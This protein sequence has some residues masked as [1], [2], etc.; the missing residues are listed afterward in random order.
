MHKY[1]IVALAENQINDEEILIA[2]LSI[3]KRDNLYESAILTQNYVFVFELNSITAQ[4]IMENPEEDIFLNLHDFSLKKIV[5]DDIPNSFGYFHKN[6]EDKIYDEL[7]SSRKY[8]YDLA[9]SLTDC[10]FTCHPEMFFYFQYKIILL[11]EF[12]NQMEN[13]DENLLF[14]R[15][16]EVIGVI[17][18]DAFKILTDTYKDLSEAQIDEIRSIYYD[19][20]D[21]VQGYSLPIV[22]YVTNNETAKRISC[23]IMGDNYRLHQKYIQELF[24]KSL[25]I[26]EKR[27]ILNSNSKSYFAHE[28]VI[29]SNDVQLK[30]FPTLYAFTRL[31]EV[32]QKWDGGNL[33]IDYLERNNFTQLD[34]SEIEIKA[35]TKYVFSHPEIVNPFFNDLSNSLGLSQFGRQKRN[36]M[37]ECLF[38]Q[39]QVNFTL[40]KST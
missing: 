39:S 32:A 38:N 18:M 2:L 40:Y 35:K 21:Y 24:I 3:V 12:K 25:E 36:K 1:K 27:I 26:V 29:G 23:E 20:I 15:F 4:E 34:D 28:I 5:F 7:S 16:S 19:E 9:T 33:L 8:S 37:G 14:N 10:A 30:I 11:R 17:L 22:L 31:E 6:L 13:L